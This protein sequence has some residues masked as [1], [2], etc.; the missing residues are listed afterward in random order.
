MLRAVTI[1]IGPLTS[2]FLGFVVMAAAIAILFV[3]PWLDKSPVKS[4]R[5]K[6]TISRVALI[7]F[8]A[9][10]VILGYLGVKPSTPG[11][12]MLAQACT[13]IY[14]A[15]FIAMPF[16][17]RR[18]KCL[19]VPDRVRMT[20]LS[21]GLVFGGLAL[22]VVLVILPIKAV[23]ASE[24]GPCGAVPCME[25]H[26]PFDFEDKASLQ[27][28]LKYFVAYCMGCHSLNYSRYGRVGEDLEI[29]DQVM[30][31]NVI[32][33]E[34][35]IGELMTISMSA[36][37][38]KQWF[39]A[40]PP[41]LSLVARSRSPEWLYT[42]LLT[43]YRDDT[44]PTGVNNKVFAN[45]GMPHVMLELQ[46]LLECAPGPK[47]N[48]HG[49]AER[50]DVGESV[51]I[52]CGSLAPGAIKGELGE[53]EFEKVVYDVVNFL[54]YVAE[55]GAADRKRVGIYVMLFLIVLMMFAWLL[56]REYWK[57]VH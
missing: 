42:Y 49:Q 40:M 39:G 16:W 57:D 34:Q 48:S 27:N 1:D 44:R 20:G 31:D 51:N 4:I 41:D 3:L 26:K 50:N 35:K 53:D 18:E 7:I 56:N 14:F 5:Y 52:P 33:T 25:P 6:G 54:E 28:G 10:F 30:L 13:V 55:P 36:E 37:K 19:P 21:K 8:A 24:G 2:K 38:G 22:F 29:P 47:T 12:T 46:G 11:R 9:A 23:G 45:V 32:F 43:F 15:Y 17:T